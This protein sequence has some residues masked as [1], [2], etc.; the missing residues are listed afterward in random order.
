MTGGTR[1]RGYHS[2]SGIPDARVRLQRLQGLPRLEELAILVVT[3]LSFFRYAP[4]SSYSLAVENFGL[5]YVESAIPQRVF[6]AFKRMH[7]G[8]GSDRIVAIKVPPHTLSSDSQRRQRYFV[9]VEGQS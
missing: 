6:V 7:T 3:S 2:R 9:A 4:I 8:A 1:Q 5:Q